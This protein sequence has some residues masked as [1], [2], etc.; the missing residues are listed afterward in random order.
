MNIQIRIWWIQVWLFAFGKNVGKEATLL[1][2]F[3]RHCFAPWGTAGITLT[4]E[5][6]RLVPWTSILTAVRLLTG[7]RKTRPTQKKQTLCYWERT[8]G[9]HKWC[10]SS[11]L[12]L[13]NFNWKYTK[14]INPKSLYNLT[15]PQ[16]LHTH[17]ISPQI[18]KQNLP[19]PQM[20]PHPV[21]IASSLP[22][23]TTIITST[24]YFCVLLNVIS[25]NMCF[26]PLFWASG[27]FLSSLI[28]FTSM[29]DTR[30]SIFRKNNAEELYVLRI[31]VK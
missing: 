3:P 27:L 9:K 29:R 14:C 11:I 2:I 24:Y 13:A 16:S 7:L 17:V 25:Y 21:T 30:K 10:L 19:V 22:R 6:P 1:V 20:L 5:N 4:W 15:F 31:N 28:N 18:K 23:I 26:L 12:I 8:A